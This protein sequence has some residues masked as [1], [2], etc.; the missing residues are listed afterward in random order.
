[1]SWIEVS[2]DIKPGSFPNAIN[3]GSH[4]TIPVAFLSDEDFDARS[5]N[6]GSVTL[7]GIDFDSGLIAMRGKKDAQPMASHEDVDGDGDVD[8]M[9][10][11][12][13]EKLA[14]FEG[15]LQALVTLGALTFDGYVASGTDTVRIKNLTAFKVDIGAEGQEVEPGFIGWSPPPDGDPGGDT[16]LLD[17]AGTGIN[18]KL[19]TGL[20][21]DD[22]GFRGPG[23]VGV[24]PYQGQ[25]YLAN[26]FLHPDN[27]GGGK[28]VV[29]AQCP[30]VNPTCEPGTI[31][32]TLSNVPAGQYQLTGYHNEPRLEN[33]SGTPDDI[34]VSPLNVRISGAVSGA[35]G[36]TDVIVTGRDTNAGIGQ[37][38]STF[39]A[40]GDGD[41]IIEFEPDGSLSGPSATDP[42][43]IRNLW[44]RAW[45]NGFELRSQ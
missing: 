29:T 43:G 35:T 8:L 24:R 19:E 15:E 16:V 13:T 42:S 31:I 1:V 38:T 10:H 34:G 5:I 23:I 17:I 14:E 36:D 40:T 44:D 39:T 33:H 28:D 30:G 12:D 27:Y 25:N 7:R 6:P 3:L 26:D 11:L 9:V 20:G 41:V 45:L 4:G 37:S 21:N 18:A 32:L 2:V 22:L